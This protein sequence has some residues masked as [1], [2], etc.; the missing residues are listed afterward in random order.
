MLHWDVNLPLWATR[1]LLILVDQMTFTVYVHTTV[2]FSLFG[3][4][5][6]NL[7]H[8]IL[9]MALSGSWSRSISVY[10]SSQNC[11]VP[12]TLPCRYQRHIDLIL[13]LMLVLIGVA[14]FFIPHAPSYQVFVVLAILNTIGI[15]AYDQGGQAWWLPITELWLA[16]LWKVSFWYDTYKIFKRKLIILLFTNYSWIICKIWPFQPD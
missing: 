5:C 8:L 16:L 2:V 9:L 12:L 13:G 6:S 3:P 14:T 4:W 15:V 10:V 7:N 11:A 1:Q